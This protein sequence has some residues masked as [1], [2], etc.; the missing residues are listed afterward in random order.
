MAA[1]TTTKWV[2]LDYR[3]V[4]RLL[5]SRSHGDTAAATQFASRQNI[6]PLSG[7]LL[8]GEDGADE[9]GARPS[10]NAPDSFHLARQNK[11][12]SSDYH[13]WPDRYG[14]LPTSQRVFN[15][16]GGPGD[17]LCVPDPTNPP[18]MCTA[19]SLA[20][21]LAE[22]VPIH[23]VLAFPPQQITSPLA[24]EAAACHVHVS[25]PIETDCET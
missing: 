25:D 23:D 24:I 6:M 13:G 10:N 16:V 11:D 21:I 19:G 1:L 8:V 17:D 12:G 22:N 9:R 14:F 2:L 5:G 15:P 18:S 20:Q 7:G 3:G 4:Q